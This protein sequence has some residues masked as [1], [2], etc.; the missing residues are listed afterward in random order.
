MQLAIWSVEFSFN[1]IMYWQIDGVAMGSA[2]GPALANI[3]IDYQKTKLFLNLKK[4]LIYYRYIDDTFSVFENEDDCKN[5]LS[6]LNSLYSLLCFTFKKINSWDISCQL[7]SFSAFVCRPSPIFLKFGMFVGLNQQ[8]S[9]TKF[10]V[11]KL[12]S[13]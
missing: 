10:Q 5:F 13:F 3:F 1:D 6:S 12:N 9:H 2:L 8:M 7:T 4:P 11:Y